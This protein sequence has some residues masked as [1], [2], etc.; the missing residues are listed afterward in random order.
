M[1]IYP[2]VSNG[3]SRVINIVGRVVNIQQGLLRVAPVLTL[4]NKAAYHLRNAS[5]IIA[6][7]FLSE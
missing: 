6:F 1:W 4:K 5:L 2:Q 3:P 7:L